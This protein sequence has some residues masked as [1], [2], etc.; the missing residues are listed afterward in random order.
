MLWL[1]PMA[2]LA[3]Q[4][5]LMPELLLLIAYIPLVLLALFFDAGKTE[6]A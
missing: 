5:F 1:L 2:Y 6:N 4:R 3:S